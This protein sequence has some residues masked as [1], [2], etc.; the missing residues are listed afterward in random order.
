MKFFVLLVLFLAALQSAWALPEAEL[1]R[2]ID[3]AIKAGGG[4]V[5]IPPGV[6]L[7]EHGLILKAAKKL[8]IIGLDAEESVLKGGKGVT[9]LIQLGPGCENV[10]IEKLTFDGSQSAVSEWHDPREP[11]DNAGKGIAK[12]LL[13]RC[14]FQNEKE[15]A[16]LL[17]M[18]R[19]DGLSIEDCSFRDIGQAAIYLGEKT[20]NS[21]ITHNQFIR[22][23]S[24]VALHGSQKCLVASD[25]LKDCRT[26]I[27]ITGPKDKTSIDQGNIIAINAI[28]GSAENAIQFDL[29]TQ[30]NSAL[31][32]EITRSGKNGIQLDGAGNVLKG[33]KI[34][35]S[36]GKDIA[37]I[38]GKHEI[39]E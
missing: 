35:G 21:S 15:N 31:Q 7:I 23:G 39:V 16:V 33:N 5:A 8:R 1:Q 26:G 6:H 3:E 27:L 30:K 22:C 18:A 25:E 19:V 29:R 10:R 36:G 11:A 28:E 13:S 20:S 12:I 14:F 4:E 9:A 32:N 24:G 38:A 2:Y 17:P 34:S 37:V